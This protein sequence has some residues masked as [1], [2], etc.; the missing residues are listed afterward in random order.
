MNAWCLRGDAAILIQRDRG[1]QRRVYEQ[2]VPIV[3]EAIQKGYD[4]TKQEVFVALFGV[5]IIMHTN[6]YEPMRVLGST[7]EAMIPPRRG[8]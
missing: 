2:L 8:L 6:D 4:I 5:A 3:K 7:A 1:A